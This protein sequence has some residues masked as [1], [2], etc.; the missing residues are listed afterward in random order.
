MR[1]AGS[2]V[3][4]YSRVNPFSVNFVLKMKINIW[5]VN[6]I[7][8]APCKMYK[9][10]IIEGE[11]PGGNANLESNLANSPPANCTDP[12]ISQRLGNQHRKI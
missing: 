5:P 2:N 11:K 10:I 7:T 8:L 6:I 1:G 12:L 9:K 3:C 4:V